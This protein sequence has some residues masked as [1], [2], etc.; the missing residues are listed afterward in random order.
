MADELWGHW[1][2]NYSTPIDWCAKEVGGH[3]F[4]ATWRF[5]ASRLLG[6]HRCRC[7]SRGVWLD[8]YS[9]NVFGVK[10]ECVKDLLV[11]VCNG[12]SKS[13]ETVS[14]DM[15]VSTGQHADCAGG[16]IPLY[17]PVW[18]CGRSLDQVTM[19]GLPD[20][21]VDVAEGTI[22]YKYLDFCRLFWS[23]VVEWW[24]WSV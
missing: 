24:F 3:P 16:R 5:V 12:T 4:C 14:R 19:Q 11:N 20:N 2:W 7:H 18:M 9:I 22:P 8:L 15:Q 17:I 1:V 6:S 13:A 23:R 10:V 21:N